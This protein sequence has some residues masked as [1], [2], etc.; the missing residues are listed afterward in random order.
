MHWVGFHCATCIVQNVYAFGRISL[1][2]MNC[3]KRAG[4]HVL[5][6]IMVDKVSVICSTSESLCIAQGADDRFFSKPRA[7]FYR[8]S[9]SRSDI[10]L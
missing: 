9:P 4:F 10:F 5:V 2:H 7:S 8:M 3:A 6:E 1:P